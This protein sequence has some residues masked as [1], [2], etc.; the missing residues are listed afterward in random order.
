MSIEDGYGDSN[1]VFKKKDGTRTS[2]KV[3]GLLR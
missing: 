1:I 2:I 3:S